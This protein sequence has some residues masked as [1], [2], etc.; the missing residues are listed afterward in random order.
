MTDQRQVRTGNDHPVADSPLRLL[1]NPTMAG[2]CGTAC[3]LDSLAKSA[4]VLRLQ[5]RAGPIVPNEPLQELC[6]REREAEDYTKAEKQLSDPCA[7]AVAVAFWPADFELPNRMQQ[8]NLWLLEAEGL[9]QWDP[10]R[11]QYILSAITK[12][13]S[14]EGEQWT[15]EAVVLANRMLHCSADFETVNRQVGEALRTVV[16][17]AIADFGEEVG[18]T[19]IH[20]LNVIDQC[21]RLPEMRGIDLGT[22]NSCIAFAHEGKA[23]IFKGKRGVTKHFRFA[24][25]A[26]RL[27]VFFGR[28]GCHFLFVFRHLNHSLCLS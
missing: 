10:N 28:C 16:E 2:D 12:W 17:R 4:R 8:A 5:A 25:R 18:P 3:T 21:K 7:L 24:F 22:S 6:P 19:E 27:R 15:Q 1:F 26:R 20:L 14:L 13:D 11:T 23:Q 9:P